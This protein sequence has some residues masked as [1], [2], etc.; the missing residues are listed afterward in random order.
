MDPAHERGNSMDLM[1]SSPEGGHSPAEL[2][3][4][5]A[6]RGRQLGRDAVLELP[7][8]H[9]KRRSPPA[10]DRDASSER[11]P[12]L[13]ARPAEWPRLQ[14]E[15]RAAQEQVRHLAAA[16]QLTQE[17]L[18]RARKDL[19]DESA[20]HA[21]DDAPAGGA[22]SAPDAASHAGLRLHMLGATRIELDGELVRGAW[23]AQ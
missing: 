14:V 17:E 23:L 12:E 20:R 4:R 15:L 19:E 2:R 16:V 11:I 13:A 10:H 7:T 21:A 9:R 3:D 1:T 18:A 6:P 5:A 8:A 22:P